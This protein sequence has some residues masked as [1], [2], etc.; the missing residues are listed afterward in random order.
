MEEKK[1]SKKVGAAASES[2]SEAQAQLLQ[3]W[4][5]AAS[6]GNNEAIKRL[7]NIVGVNARNQ[8]GE[9]ALYRAVLKGHVSTVELL[10]KAKADVHMETINGVTPLHAAVIEKH[11]DVVKLLLKAKAKPDTLAFP[12]VYG[13]MRPL[14]GAV[15]NGYGSIAKLLLDAKADVNAWHVGFAPLHHAAYDDN[16]DMAK[17]LLEAK[18]SANVTNMEGETPLKVTARKHNNPEMVKILLEA[19]ANVESDHAE[20]PASKQHLAM[21][22]QQ[23]RLSYEHDLLS[24]N[25]LSESARNKR[26]GVEKSLLEARADPYGLNQNEDDNQ[27]FSRGPGRVGN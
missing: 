27:N 26:D 20:R 4:L 22:D 10:L 2:Q 13:G 12:E 14:G 21:C 9:T 18:A 15:V 23:L 3:L 16:L 8:D 1:P 25:K 5:Q 7:I 11:E 24:D 6:E 17:L 19:K